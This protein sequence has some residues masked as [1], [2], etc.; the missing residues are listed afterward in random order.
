M[1]QETKKTDM[2]LMES[3]TL[4]ETET[5]SP[6]VQTEQK[7]SSAESS[8]ILG[9]EFVVEPPT[10]EEIAFQKEMLER[11]IE[12][13]IEWFTY[14]QEA[15]NFEAMSRKEKAFTRLLD[16]MV[17]LMKDGLIAYVERE[18]GCEEC[19]MRINERQLGLP[20]ALAEMVL[21]DEDG[22]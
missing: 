13:S 2:E 6:S 10:E 1:S 16:P 12:K 21:Q 20:L 4:L 7:T 18:D 3:S 15:E 9:T 8:D 14:G 17:W 11:G 19:T 22:D 5:E